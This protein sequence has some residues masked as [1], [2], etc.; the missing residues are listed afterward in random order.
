MAT[1]Y[2]TDGNMT[3]GPSPYRRT[4]SPTRSSATPCDCIM[5]S[6]LNLKKSRDLADVTSWVSS[7]R[8]KAMTTRSARRLSS[9]WAV[10]CGIWCGTPSRMATC[11]RRGLTILWDLHSRGQ[12]NWKGGWFYNMDHGKT[13]AVSEKLK[14]A[15][16]LIARISLGILSFA[17]LYTAPGSSRHIERMVLIRALD[18]SGGRAGHTNKSA[19][20]AQFEHNKRFYSW[21]ST[22]DLSVIALGPA[23]ICASAFRTP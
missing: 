17:R 13:H 18:R 9:G 21:H 10:C 2:E 8:P 22:S 11:W 4:A 1:G 19:R 20:T 15:N 23:C 16:V 14:S 3:P 12:D 7:S 5:C 6:E